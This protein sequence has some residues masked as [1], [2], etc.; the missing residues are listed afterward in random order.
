[1]FP[2]ISSWLMFGLFFLIITLF[3]AAADF[4]L[5]LLKVHP[6]TT[7]RIVHILV[8]VLVCFAPFF[9]RES[10]PVV[11]LAAVF[12]LINYFGIRYGLLKGIHETDRVSYGTVYFPISFLVLVLWFWDKD[13]AIL[14]TAMLIMTFGD[15]IAG[16]VG[17]SRKHP[18]FFKIWSDKKSLQGSTAMFVTAFLVAAT[19]MYFFRRLFG[20]ELH[21][22]TAVLF[23][24]FTAVYAAVS[25]TISHEGTD[26]LMV[27]LGSAVILDFLYTGSPAMQHQLMLWMILTAGIAW[28]AWKVKALSLSGAVGAWLLGTVVFGIGGLEWMFPVIFFFVTSSLFT[29]VGKRHKKILETV[30]EK[31]GQRDIFQVFANGGVGMFAILGYYFAPHSAWYMIFL[32]S[33]AAATA[34]TWATELG[35]F[36]RRPPVSILNFKKVEMGTSGGITPLGTFGALIGSLSVVLIGGFM[37]GWRQVDF[38]TVEHIVVITLAGF[39]GSVVDSIL[40]ATVQA[41]YRCPVCGKIT[42]KKEHCTEKNIPLIR[43]YRFMNNDRVNLMCTLTGGLL[44]ALAIFF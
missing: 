21:W 19:G 13:P 20:S 34:D 15:P 5:R 10:L 33:I 32:G 23:G 16:W 29:S 35:T 18:V 38:L 25:E 2:N 7:R 12:I 24:F 37:W 26:N 1:M 4:L 11:I 8:G 28:L 31:G 40:G 17:E 43:G 44:A 27:P 30:F 39:F 42:E 36:S 6:H 3:L 41:Q 14:L 22:G 9:F